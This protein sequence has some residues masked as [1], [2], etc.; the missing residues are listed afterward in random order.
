VRRDVK[1][2]YE[3]AL[4]GEIKNFTGVSDPYEAPLNPQ[5]VVDSEAENVIQS[6]DRIWNYLLEN[7]FIKSEQP[8][9]QA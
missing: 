1:G 7:S 4:H 3:K 6:A 2:L 5:V 8:V 9:L